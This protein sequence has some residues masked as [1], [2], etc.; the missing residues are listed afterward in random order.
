MEQIFV[1]KDGRELGPYTNDQVLWL[2]SQG[3]LARSDQARSS[4]TNGWIALQSIIA[5][6]HAAANELPNPIGSPVRGI[7]FGDIVLFFVAYVLLWNITLEKVLIPISGLVGLALCYLGCAEIPSLRRSL[8]SVVPITEARSK[9]I[10]RAIV[11]VLLAALSLALWVPLFTFPRL[12]F[13]ERVASGQV[14][15]WFV[16]TC[17]FGYAF[18]ITRIQRKEWKS[19]QAERGRIQLQEEKRIV[20]HP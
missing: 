8:Y 12:F 2:I 4:N 14:I 13:W 9:E 16:N 10:S 3:F 17:L 11:A 5:N 6:P 20:R 19:V 7:R 15:L 1:F 18:F